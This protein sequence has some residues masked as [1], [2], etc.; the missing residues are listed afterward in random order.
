M[1]KKANTSGLIPV[2]RAVLVEPYEPEIKKGL[3]E[4]PVTVSERTMQAEMRAVVVA[5]GP[6]AW[7][8]ET[9]PR[10]KPG[11]KVLVSKYAGAICKGTLD[12]CLYRVVNA[13]DVFL[14]I[15]AEAEA[16]E[17]VA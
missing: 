6:E 4:I 13:N 1:S 5:V 14:L 12:G 3:I 15:E 8:D 2:G 9:V 17:A 16:L 10:A 7:K 11:D